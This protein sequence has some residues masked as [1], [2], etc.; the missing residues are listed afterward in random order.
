MKM[1][2]FLNHPNILKLYGYFDDSIHVYLILEFMEEGT[3]FSKLKLSKEK[4]F[5]EKAASQKIDDILHAL[6]YMHE[7]EIAHRD[8][9]PENIVISNVIFYL[10][11]GRLQIMRFRLGCSLLEQKNDSLWDN[12]LCAAISLI[13]KRVRNNNGPVVHGCAMLRVAGR[14]G[15]ILQCEQKAN[16]T[17]N[18][19]S[20]H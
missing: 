3:L 1:Q 13:R 15:S 5:E 18:N 14:K 6:K 8:I 2:L 20:W 19:K 7:L 11:T 12:W 17:E 9:K 16:D 10:M 4:H